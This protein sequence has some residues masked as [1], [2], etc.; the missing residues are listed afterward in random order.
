[1][2]QETIPQFRDMV[3]YKAELAHLQSSNT[4]RERTKQ[5]ATTNIPLQSLQFWKRPYLPFV[6]YSNTMS[7]GCS[8]IK[9]KTGTGSGR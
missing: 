6:I 9:M 5:T 3:T 7:N 8:R 2:I 1:M 4:K